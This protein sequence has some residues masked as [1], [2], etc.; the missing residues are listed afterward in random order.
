M[1][2][3][4]LIIATVFFGIIDLILVAGVITWTLIEI[5]AM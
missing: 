2:N 4:H 3:T 5:G 1:T